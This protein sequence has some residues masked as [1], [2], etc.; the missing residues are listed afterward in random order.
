MVFIKI[1]GRFQAQVSTLTGSGSIGNYNTHALAQVVQNGKVYEVPV[2]TGNS[3]KHWHSYYLASVYQDMGGTMLNDLS[4]AGIGLRGYTVDSTF[5]NLIPPN[6]ESEAILDLCNDIHGFLIPNT[7]I[8]RDSLVKFSFAIPILDDVNLE[9]ASR[10]AVTHN[11]VVPPNV[12]EAGQGSQMM[13]FKQEYSTASYGF[14]V[15]VNL[16]WV[17]KPLFEEEEKLLEA[18]K[19]YLE[20]EKNEIEK[21]LI[22][23]KKLRIKSAVLA[24]LNLISGFGS[25]QAR[26][27]PI[28]R[29]EEIIV[30][31]SNRQI[32][33]AV[34]GA[35]PDYFNKSIDQIKAFTLNV[36][37]TSTDV[38]CYG[39]KAQSDEAEK[40]DIKSSFKINTVN[41]LS[42]MF[43]NLLKRID[44]L[45]KTK[46]G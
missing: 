32:P 34:N 21:E 46:G 6:S 11:R 12:K 7:Q 24:L 35:Y 36:R 20:K 1:S 25:K 13:V 9:T 26:A 15:S 42:T 8:K 4:K 22:N 28:E 14:S 30:V 38:Y 5:S 18:Y 10:F 2:L 40:N 43:D 44:E 41:D 29:I 37:N 17:L 33:N 31:I 3:F 45:L 39:I 23:E 27:L 19:G 16:A